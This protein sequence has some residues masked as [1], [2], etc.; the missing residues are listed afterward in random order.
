MKKMSNPREHVS[1]S[2]AFTPDEVEWLGWVMTDVLRGV[3]L[4]AAQKKIR[5]KLLTG[6][7][8]LND[9]LA[10]RF[11]ITPVQTTAKKEVPKNGRRAVRSKVKST[12]RT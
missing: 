6:L 4:T 8:M 12:R 3:K 9:T 10:A 1:I 2:I 11:G 5:T 7:K